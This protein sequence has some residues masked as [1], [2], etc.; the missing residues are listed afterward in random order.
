MATFKH[1]GTSRG[2]GAAKKGFDY[3]VYKKGGK[4]RKY[5]DGGGIDRTHE[6]RAM[7]FSDL[8][9]RKKP[10]DAMDET[11]MKAAREVERARS[12]EPAK[13]P[14]EDVTGGVSPL[15]GGDT[16]PRPTAPQRRMR[17]R[18]PMPPPPR[19][20]DTDVMRDVVR[21]KAREE[22]T[23]K[24]EMPSEIYQK[25]GGVKMAGGGSCRGM[26]AAQRGG[27]YTIK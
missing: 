11:N 26:G 2:A 27:K 15:Q 14:K 22:R 1:G 19:P 17:R 24:A 6:T 13:P 8:F 21:D 23:R 10:A 18:I 20:S 25:G 5:A 16:A 9:G 7:R 12:E 3:A 4:V